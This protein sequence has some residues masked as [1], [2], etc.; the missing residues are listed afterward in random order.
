MRSTASL[1]AR[2]GFAG[3]VNT[4]VGVA[5]VAVLDPLLGVAPPLA[6]AIGYLAGAGV[7]FVLNRAFV[8]RSQAALPA[9][10]LRYAAAAAAA[11]TLNQGVLHIAGSLLGAGQAQ[12]MAAQLLAMASY[13]LALFLLCRFWV[14]R[15]AAGSPAA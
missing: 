14:F 4:A 11:F 8:F 15:P 7:G 2:F 1:I 12:R 3:L 10:G 13:S 5:V 6:N 9:A